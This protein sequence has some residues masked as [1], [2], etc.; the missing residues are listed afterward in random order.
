MEGV[1]S[2]KKDNS[3]R[4]YPGVGG[5]RHNP[6]GK[7]AR[8]KSQEDPKRSEEQVRQDAWTKLG[9]KGQLAALDGRLGKGVGA[10]KQRAR[11]QNLIDNP[12]KPVTKKAKE[13]PVGI[14]PGELVVVGAE[15]GER[16][17]A[18][19]RKASERAKRPGAE[20]RGA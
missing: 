7:A 5:R 14:K 3:K 4:R 20:A 17:K 10:K 8:L 16:L 13:S 6:V 2:G 1:K 15:T 12:P 9:P 11:L 19:D 18:K